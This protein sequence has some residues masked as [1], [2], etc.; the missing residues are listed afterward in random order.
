M[1]H[2]GQRIRWYVFN[3]DL[4][5][6]W[7]NFHPHA[8]R[9]VFAGETI[10]IRSIGPAESFVVETVTPPVL[11]LPERIQEQPGTQASPEERQPYASAATSWCTATSRCT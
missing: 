9:W 7:H 6:T 3:L 1:A 5:M 11:L 10:D 2:T 8:L 4:G